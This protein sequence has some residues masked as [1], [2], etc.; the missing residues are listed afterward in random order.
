MEKK[1]ATKTFPPLV[2]AIYDRMGSGH[3]VF[4]EKTENNSLGQS[5]MHTFIEDILDI[6]ET[7]P[8]SIEAV[9]DLFKFFQEGEI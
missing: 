5:G 7:A 1:V 9:K 3:I 8:D 4:H 6:V 2:R